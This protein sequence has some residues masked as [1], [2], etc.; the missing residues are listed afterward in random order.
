[1]SISST[2]ACDWVHGDEISAD[3]LIRLFTRVGHSHT[4]SAH[5]AEPYWLDDYDDDHQYL[6]SVA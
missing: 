5:K 3:L 2:E 6:P 1:M 4:N